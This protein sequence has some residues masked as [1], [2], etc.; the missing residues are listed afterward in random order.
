MTARLPSDQRRMRLAFVFAVVPCGNYVVGCW[1]MMP[2][3]VKFHK[4]WCFI[5]FF[6]IIWLPGESPRAGLL[7]RKVVGISDWWIQ[8]VSFSEGAGLIVCIES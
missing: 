7:S 5:S 6:C 8:I 4:F 1:E 3:L 2:D